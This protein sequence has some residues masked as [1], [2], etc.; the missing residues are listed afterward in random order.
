MGGFSA[1]MTT[2]QTLVMGSGSGDCL[3]GAVSPVSCISKLDL[4]TLHPRKGVGSSEVT[5]RHHLD[6][7]STDSADSFLT[8]WSVR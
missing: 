5:E 8:A 6:V 2:G 3:P 4:H 1:C 7:H